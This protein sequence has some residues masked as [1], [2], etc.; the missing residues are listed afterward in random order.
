M[1]AEDTYLRSVERMLRGI[2]PEHRTAVLD[3]LRAHFADAEDAGRAVDDT[4]TS[5]GTPKQIAERAHEEFGTDDSRAERAWRVLQGTAVAIAVVIGVVVAFILPTHTIA[6]SQGGESQLHHLT[7]YENDGLWIA[8]PALVPA[9]IAAVPLVVPRAARTV[10]A[11]VCGVLLAAMALI[12]GFTLG[13]FFLPTVLLT[14]T[15]LIVWIRLRGHGFGLGWRV[16]G[17]ALTALPVAAVLT[18]AIGSG[19]VGISA[20]GWPILAAIVTLAVLIAIGYRSA[21][22]L[23]ACIGLVALVSGLLSGQLLTLLVIWL[24]GW[25]LSIGLAHGFT[26]TKRP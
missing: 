3:D 14:W 10:V 2:A 1:N 26:A 19:T 23:L 4:I 25:W 7:V 18:G 5:L 16:L 13:G 11:S 24:G 6:T 12:G 8:L 20:W 22:W 15:G 21:G 17:A 9:L